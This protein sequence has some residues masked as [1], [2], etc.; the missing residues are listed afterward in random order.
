[1]IVPNM[2]VNDAAINPP[3]SIAKLAKT[4]RVGDAVEFNYLII[5]DKIYAAP[6][7]LLKPL[8]RKSGTAPFTFI[9]SYTKR[10]GRNKFRYV[11]AN[12]GVIPCTF[13]VA[14]GVSLKGRPEPDRK[15]TDALK[16]FCLGDKVELDYETMDYQFVLKGIRQCTLSGRGE[17]TKITHR[18]FRGRKHVVAVI[19]TPKRT[20]KLTDPEPIIPPKGNAPTAMSL[21]SPVQ[22]ALKKLQPGDHVTFKY[23]RKGGI[24]WL[25][26]VADADHAAAVAARVRRAEAH[27]AR[28]KRRP[29]PTT[30]PAGE[31][32]WE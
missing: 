28:A 10:V 16:G 5:N 2:S 32:I 22:A 20:L 29:A 13:R 17:L 19:R 1:M 7:T 25:D 15:V 21:D 12:A 9:R 4:L 18:R 6:I 26:Q 30:R 3:P 23:R 31:I 14:E 24:Y 11:I 8:S 27:R